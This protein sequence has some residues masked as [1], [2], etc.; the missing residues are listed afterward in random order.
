MRKTVCLLAVLL[1]GGC[2]D[3]APLPMD[4]AVRDLSATPDL[5]PF[6]C[7]PV[8]QDCPGTQKC[9]LMEVP[10]GTSLVPFCTAAGTATEN[11]PCTRDGDAG[12]GYDDCAKGLLCIN[13]PDGTQCL[14][15]CESSAG[16][17][18]TRQ[19]CSATP[20]LGFCLTAC[21]IQG[22]DCPGGSSCAGSYEELGA[23]TRQPVCRVDGP[24]ALGA[25]CTADADCV[26][27]AFCA[28]TPK[29][30]RASCNGTHGCTGGA[31]TPLPN[32]S[33]IIALG[34]CN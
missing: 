33:G 24:V 15:F 32:T 7:D 30:C 3:D 9:T 12:V 25:S 23:G 13:P 4:L 28:G 2:D 11:Q 29:T 6:T 26:A 10:L 16:C 14:K 1:G 20:F 8:A 27:N 21:T 31:C 18:R 22:S 34:Y 17:T 19:F 5:R